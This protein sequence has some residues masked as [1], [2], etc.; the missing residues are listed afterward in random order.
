L[1]SAMI[2]AAMTSTTIRTCIHSQK[3]DTEAAP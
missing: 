1:V 3:G 2:A